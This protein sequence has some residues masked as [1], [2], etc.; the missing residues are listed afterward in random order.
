MEGKR[1]VK[2]FFFFLLSV[3]NESGMDLLVK[4]VMLL[5]RNIQFLFSEIE[6]HHSVAVSVKR[7]L[8]SESE[9]KS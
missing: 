8:G 5:V 1:A 2:L 3:E 7:P 9:L 6:A 4:S